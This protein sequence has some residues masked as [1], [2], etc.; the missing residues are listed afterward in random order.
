MSKFVAVFGMS[1]AIKPLV[2]SDNTAGILGP[3]GFQFGKAKCQGKHIYWDGL[4]VQVSGVTA[5]GAGA[6]IPDPAVYF[7]NFQATCQKVKHLSELVLRV[8]DE[9][10]QITATP[11]IPGTPPTPYPTTFTIEIT[12]A[13]QDKVKA[14]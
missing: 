13:G 3:L 9:T 5:P 10:N 7:G 14:L 2:P 11:Q 1:I 4:Q 8:D 12:N 6:T